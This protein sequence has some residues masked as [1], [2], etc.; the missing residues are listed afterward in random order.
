MKTNIRNS[1]HI[2]SKQEIVLFG[3][4]QI[5]G[6]IFEHSGPSKNIKQS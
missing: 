3:V 6:V 4:E 5:G 1:F 2:N